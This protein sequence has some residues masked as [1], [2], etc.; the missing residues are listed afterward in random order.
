MVLHSQESKIEVLKYELLNVFEETSEMEIKGLKI[1]FEMDAMNVIN[2]TV[3]KKF[4][5]H[6]VRELLR[7]E[8]ERSCIN[9][10][11]KR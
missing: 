10:R 1:N 6:E 9:R 8:L 5:I 4:C 11:E 3:N 7:V 2:M